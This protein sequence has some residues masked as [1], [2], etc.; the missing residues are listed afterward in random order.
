[1]ELFLVPMPCVVHL[2]ATREYSFN[3]SGSNA[4]LG[5]KESNHS[6]HWLRIGETT[7]ISKRNY[8]HWHGGWCPAC[9]ES[10]RRRADGTATFSI[11]W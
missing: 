1:M 6:L 7:H 9:R 3:D 11:Y 8:T 5:P 2:R 10:G 4:M